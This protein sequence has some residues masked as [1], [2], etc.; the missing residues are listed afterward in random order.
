M[1][2]SAALEAFG[3]LLAIVDEL[4]RKCPWDQQQTMGSLRHLTVEETFELTEAILEGDVQ[5]IEKELG[6]LLLHIVL[7]ARI[8]AEQHSFTITKVI[9]TL[10]AKLIHRHP[11]IYGQGKAK[12][13][14]TV[15][16]NWERLKE[17]KSV[18]G[19]VPRTLPSL[20]KAM[21]IQEK[22][23]RI[24]FDWQGKE[25]LQEQMQEKIKILMNQSNQDVFNKQTIEDMW[26]DTLFLLVYY[27]ERASINIENALEKAN[28]KFIA[29]FQY[30]E[31]QIVRDGKQITQLAARE[32]MCY[33]EKA[34]QRP[35]N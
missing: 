5:E 23:S 27:A 3:R 19:G 1:E 14:Q 24:G 29:H 12:D 34:M 25:A 8:A 7:Y 30:M 4:R 18:L 20:I 31:Q 15:K 17:N 26:G 2:N 16:K 10:C 13:I 6:D 22:V 9:Q 21:R 11:H 32:L 35:I 28:R 33:W